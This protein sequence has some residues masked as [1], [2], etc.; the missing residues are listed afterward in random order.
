MK[1]IP[2][3]DA[4]NFVLTLTQGDTNHKRWVTKEFYSKFDGDEL[5]THLKT[6]DEHSYQEELKTRKPD[7]YKAEYP[8]PSQSS[9]PLVEQVETP[10]APAQK[11][12]SKKTTSSN[13]RMS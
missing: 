7:R 10:S 2:L 13:S 9:E 8:E 12:S 11:L 3:N 4:L 1:T 5:L 6:Y